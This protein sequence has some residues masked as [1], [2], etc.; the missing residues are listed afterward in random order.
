MIHKVFGYCK[1]IH[2]FGTDAEGSR[3]TELHYHLKM[4]VKIVHMC[5][6]VQLHWFYCTHV[7]LSSKINK[8]TSLLN[9]Y[10]H[11]TVKYRI[12]GQHLAHQM[13]DKVIT[14]RR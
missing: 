4:A 11:K 5:M 10:H 3:A 1:T 12:K 7:L 9:N 6:C 14:I 8:L 2:G 13:H